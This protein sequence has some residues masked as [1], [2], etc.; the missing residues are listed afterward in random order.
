[1]GFEVHE[2][3]LALGESMEALYREVGGSNPFP[4]VA[5]AVND[6][7]GG[8]HRHPRRLCGVRGRSQAFPAPTTAPGASRS[9]TA[10]AYVSPS[11]VGSRSANFRGSPKS[12]G[13]S[14]TDG[15]KFSTETGGHLARLAAP[16][17][18]IGSPPPASPGRTPLAPRLPCPEPPLIGPWGFPRRSAP[19][20][21]L[22]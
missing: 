7:T 22:P 10:R 2:T 21:K 9:A 15:W 4:R 20:S 5:R 1:M 6:L 16:A 17:H 11:M 18:G 3:L 13:S 14:R 8:A 19:Q 12:I